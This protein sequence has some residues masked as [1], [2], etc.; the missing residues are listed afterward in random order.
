MCY[1]VF[2]NIINYNSLMR[3]RNYSRKYKIQCFNVRAQY[4][5]A[6]LIQI[7]NTRII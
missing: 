7:G 5:V 2:Y 1:P 6:D 3:I 4:H